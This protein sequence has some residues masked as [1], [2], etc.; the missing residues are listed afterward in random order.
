MKK[1]LIILLTG[2]VLAACNSDDNVSQ[3]QSTESISEE[4]I[5]QSEQ[6]STENKEANATPKKPDNESENDEKEYYYVGDTSYFE[7]SIMINQPYA[8]TVN[9]FTITRE[10]KG[11][12]M[13]EYLIGFEEDSAFYLAIV[14]V[15]VTNNGSE[16]FK[17]EENSNISLLESERE[18]FN[19]M[20]DGEIS[21]LTTDIKPSESLTL[22]LPFIVNVDDSQGAY[23]MYI[24]P[25]GSVFQK[26]Y[27]LE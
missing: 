27:K 6:T 26:I 7:E 3:Q 16:T 18:G 5:N 15:T 10:F 4:E 24:D 19:Y 12:P 11:E 21:E 14:N 22:D 1:I 23:Y 2:I 13:E 20:L 8:L 9:D 25:A 17:F